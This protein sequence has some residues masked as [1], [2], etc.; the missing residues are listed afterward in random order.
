MREELTKYVYENDEEVGL[1]I[2]DPNEEIDIAPPLLILSVSCLLEKNRSSSQSRFAMCHVE[3][4]ALNSKFIILY[5]RLL[6]IYFTHF[7]SSKTNIENTFLC[8]YFSFWNVF[9]VSRV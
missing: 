5:K 3:K 2:A 7:V 6:K 9:R 8:I 4:P 1:E